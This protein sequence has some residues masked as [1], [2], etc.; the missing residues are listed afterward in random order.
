[1]TGY[2]RLLRLALL[3]ALVACG[4]AGSAPTPPP[5]APDPRTLAVHYPPATGAW[6]T[7]TPASIGWDST[8]LRSALDWAGTQKSTAVVILWRGRIVAER[9]W[10]GWTA[11]TDSIIASAGKSVLSTVIGQLSASGR[12]S[13][14]D[15]VS[16]WIG[17][18]WSRSP[19]TEARIR[20]RDLL[21]MASGLNDSLQLVV[22]PGTRFYYNNPAY[23]Q[24][25]QVAQRASGQDINAVSRALLFNAIGMTSTWRLSFDTGEPGFILS[26]TARDM[27]R[28]GLLAM[29]RGRWNG[30]PVVTDTS[31]F[32]RSWQSSTP[33][34]A[35]YGYLWWLNSGASYRMP[36][37][38]LLP[39]VSAP[40]IP[41]APRD[42]V[43]A[44][45]KGDK[46]IYVIPSLDVVVV[47]HGQEADVSG[48][49][50]LAISSFD[51]QWWQRLRAAMRY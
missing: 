5:A 6:E 26:A 29:S 49:N 51:E 4:D 2:P 23:Y 36:G 30:T 13:L 34:N 32:T 19:A 8:A 1:M 20:V 50:P 37:P 33:D 35:G 15:P 44:L 45:G 39:T 27:A 41:S 21:A 48:G 25:F 22:A 14:D 7:M 47:R 43:A 17:A 24:L 11:G 31:W 40:L 16:Q 38:Y 18:G 3:L 42:L 46:K 9:Y 10:G 28:F 12:L